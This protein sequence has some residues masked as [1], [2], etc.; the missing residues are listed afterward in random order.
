MG[1]FWVILGITV[2]IYLVLRY[3]P[4][5]KT[6]IVVDKIGME[7]LGFV[8]VEYPE[9]VLKKRIVD[10]HT[11]YEGQKLAIHD[12]FQLTQAKGWI[13]IFDLVNEVDPEPSLVAQDMVS[14]FSSELNSPR[15]VILSRLNRTGMWG[16][17]MDRFLSR[18]A[19]WENN[20][21]HLKPISFADEVDINKR[22][23][24]FG[25][26]ELKTRNFMTPGRLKCLLGLSNNYAIDLDEDLLTITMTIH[27]KDLG[28]K[29]CIQMTLN[30]A[31]GLVACLTE[32][33][34][35]EGGS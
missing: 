22:Y 6:K 18:M 20:T 10:L 33:Q 13:F 8:R 32:S 11:K 17:V 16:V 12:V 27:T 21:Q 34:V 14:I 30:E 9:G 2:V 28:R 7:S 3:Y 23:Y 35:A 15:I 1:F 19:N 4:R 31:I 29:D 5:A 25:S 24:I 26:D